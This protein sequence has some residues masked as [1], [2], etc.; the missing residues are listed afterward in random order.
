MVPPS[1]ADTKEFDEAEIEAG[2]E[3]FLNE[4]A[5]LGDNQ[6][7]LEEDK[8]KSSD[9]STIHPASPSEVLDEI[10]K[11]IDEKF[12]KVNAEIANEVNAS[13]DEKSK[14]KKRRKRKR[15]QDSEEEKPKKKKKKYRWKQCKDKVSGK[16]YFWDTQNDKTSWKEPN[17]PY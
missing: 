4:V 6:Y 2:M 17:E 3:S 9:R 1:K 11:R 16:Y 8:A 15:D 13:D 7:L 12:K 10:S 5:N 14:K